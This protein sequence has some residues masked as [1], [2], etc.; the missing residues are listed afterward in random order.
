MAAVSVG[1]LLC[2]VVPS[3][4]PVGMTHLLY[5]GYSICD[6]CVYGSFALSELVPSAPFCVK[7]LYFGRVVSI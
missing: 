7:I 3:V 5:P 6:P 4:A 1:P 2:H